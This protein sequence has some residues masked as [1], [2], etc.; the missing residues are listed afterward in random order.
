VH[1]ATALLG[2]TTH[3]ALPE[4]REHPAKGPIRLQDHGDPVGYRNIWVRA[5]KAYDEK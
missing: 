4:Y 1:H 5:L 3:R 2:G